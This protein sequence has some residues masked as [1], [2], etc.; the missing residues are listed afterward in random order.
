[1][2]FE[3]GKKET[4]NGVE[5]VCY[6][7]LTEREREVFS[8]LADLITKTLKVYTCIVFKA[9]TSKEGTKMYRVEVNGLDCNAMNFAKN[10][11]YSIDDVYMKSF[12]HYIV[13]TVSM[14]NYY[15][16]YDKSRG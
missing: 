2:K 7:K 16:F 11:I 3:V 5:V 4:I 14:F 10:P 6:D 8:M 12:F 9:Y 15:E 13:S 1:M